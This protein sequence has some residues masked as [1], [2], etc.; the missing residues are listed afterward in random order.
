M[1]IVALCVLYRDNQGPNNFQ[2]QR[3]LYVQPQR[4]P[5]QQERSQTHYPRP[6]YK[7]FDASSGYASESTHNTEI[8]PNEMSRQPNKNPHSP[9]NPPPLP[10]AQR[11]DFGR[12]SNDG[13]SQPPSHIPDSQSRQYNLNPPALRQSPYRRGNRDDGV[14]HY[15]KD[16]YRPPMSSQNQYN[17]QFQ[18]GDK[19]DSQGYHR[20][21]LAQYSPEYS[22]SI[23]NE[24][25]RP[26][27]APQK[28][29][30]NE[31]SGVEENHV[32]GVQAA[33]NIFEKRSD[34][35]RPPAAPKP[36]IAPK[37][38]N[39]NTRPIP[40]RPSSIRP[41]TGWEGGND[42]SR[43][44]G[45]PYAGTKSPTSPHAFGRQPYLPNP[46]PSHSQSMDNLD[47]R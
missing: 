24:P 7:D 46:Q 8:I 23:R 17:D 47:D 43:L 45:G 2:N 21:Q 13:Y 16:T 37:P 1:L 33:R 41:D 32:P 28:T 40:P 20:N 3:Q 30:I 9:G 44:Q 12:S 42:R 14:Q 15:T 27:H 29:N 4:P 38:G 5:A 34:P 10:E 36:I 19:Y 26:Y 35:R 11:Q 25:Q 22:I 39:V 6:G 18:R 31:G